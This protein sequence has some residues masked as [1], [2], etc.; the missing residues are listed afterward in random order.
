MQ[1][2]FAGKTKNVF[3]LPDGRYAL[4]FKDD[5][6]GEDG[7]FDPGANKVGLAL[8][9]AGEAAL[10]L[11]KFFFEEL[12]KQGVP[13]HYISADVGEKT[14]IVEAA[15]PFGAGLEVICRY[16]AVGSFYRRYGK[17]VNEGD[18]LDAF[19]EFTLKDDAREDPPI[20]E[21]ALIVLGILSKEE[22]N[23]L[24]QLTRQI[25]AFVK[26]KLAQRQMDLYDIKFEFGRIG[27]DQHIAL[28]DE[29]SAGN[30]R[31]FKDGVQVHPL[32]L[33]RLMLEDR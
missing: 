33:T 21:D 14:M 2:V 27:D 25:A 17:Y 23:T 8:E 19:V 6:T 1:L 30:M 31:A 3:R 32:E 28:I 20:T 13:T 4:K 12:R 26:E 16:R 29:I 9:G 24:C 7:V 5:V 10:R 15:T 18:R 22:Y 11:S